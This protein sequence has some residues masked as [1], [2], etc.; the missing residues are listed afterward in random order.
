MS[1]EGALCSVPEMWPNRKR[2]ENSRSRRTNAHL[3]EPWGSGKT[4]GRYWLQSWSR[5]MVS[6]TCPVSSGLMIL[7]SQPLWW[8]SKQSCWSQWGGDRSIKVASHLSTWSSPDR[9]MD[10]P[11]FPIWEIWTD[12]LEQHWRHWIDSDQVT[13]PSWNE[14]QK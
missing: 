1:L 4:L 9:I 12:D 5:L 7:M 14:I 13:L 6:L 2:Y 8:S 11:K 10:T 3:V